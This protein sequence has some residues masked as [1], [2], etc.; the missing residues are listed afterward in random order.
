MEEAQKSQGAIAQQEKSL[1]LIE[2]TEGQEASKE[3]RFVMSL[4][5]TKEKLQDLLDELKTEE[6]TLIGLSRIRVF[7]NPLL[8]EN[9]GTKEDFMKFIVLLM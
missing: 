3:V 8:S 6:N 7:Y 1:R 2:L 4:P 9:S 5:T